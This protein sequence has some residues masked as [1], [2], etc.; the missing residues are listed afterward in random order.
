MK[1][2]TAERIMLILTLVVL[3]FFA[4]FYVRGATMR[5]NAAEDAP[6]V[7]EM[8]EPAESVQPLQAPESRTLE[9][10]SAPEPTGDPADGLLD[11]NAATAEELETLP[12]IGPVLAQRILDYRTACGGFETLDE[13]LNVEGI[14][15]KTYKAIYE[16]LK[17]GTSQ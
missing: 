7:Q 11:L 5:Q 9:A 12:G 10:A 15:E 13:L 8:D 2:T 16:L 14:G 4:G 3:A 1:I 17:V 6:A